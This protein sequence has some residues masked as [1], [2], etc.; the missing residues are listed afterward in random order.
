MNPYPFDGR[1]KVE[2]ESTALGYSTGK[3]DGETL[4]KKSETNR[5]DEFGC[6]WNSRFEGISQGVLK[7][8]SKADPT[9]A[10][11]GFRLDVPDGSGM[12]GREPQTF[13]TMMDVTFNDS[14]VAE[15]SGKVEANGLAV[16]ITMTR[17]GD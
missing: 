14:K 8:I 10:E 6:K 2:T 5:V 11:E 13:E 16:Y 12:N 9:N 4:I 1:Y 17:I 15:I 3:S 7:M